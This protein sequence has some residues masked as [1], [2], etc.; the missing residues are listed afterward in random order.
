MYYLIIVVS[1]YKKNIF[2]MILMILNLYC[3]CFVAIGAL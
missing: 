3:K 1:N 2:F